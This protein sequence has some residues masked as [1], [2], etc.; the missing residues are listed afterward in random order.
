MSSSFLK[1]HTWCFH[2]THTADVKNTY[3]T[4]IREA[5]T[6]QST[7]LE[8]PAITKKANIAHDCFYFLFGGDS[9]HLLLWSCDGG[10]CN[11]TLMM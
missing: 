11:S 5:A 9:P 1:Q 6:F 2:T 4:V 7:T 10:Y 8:Y 3:C